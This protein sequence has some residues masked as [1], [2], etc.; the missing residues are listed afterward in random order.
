MFYL[1]IKQMLSRKSQTILIFLGISFGTMIYV[2]IAGL[3]F[4]FRTYLTEQ[5]LNNTAHV[6]IKGV[7]QNIE[8]DPLRKRFYS[9]DIHVKWIS[10]PEG[11]RDEVKLQ[12]PQG[13]FDRLDV[14]PNVVAY[15]PRL[16]I[17]GLVSQGR[18]RT[19]VNITGIIPNR[20]MKVTS[21]EEYMDEGSLKDLNG[22]GNKIILGSGV[23]KDIGAQ[24]GDTVNISAGL[25]ESR[26]FKVVGKVHLG[27]EQI[28]KAMV[29]GNIREIQ[30][31]N[32]S[33]GRVSE[34]SVSLV[35]IKQSQEIA[36]KWAKYTRDKVQGWEEANAQFMQMIQIQDIM[37][38]IMTGAILLVAGFGI[39][40]VLSIMISQKKKE[41]AILRSIGYGPNRI[42]ELFLFQGLM[43][44]FGGGILGIILGFTV[45]KILE[46]YELA[47]EVGKS[48]HLPISY[49]LSI[50]FTALIAAQAAAAIASY[51][52][53]RAASRLTPLEIIREEM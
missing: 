30:S 7:E 32:R 50:F 46:S 16:S 20:Q 1:A 19:N 38:A 44:G 41:I 4:G 25:G 8:K 39:Y 17:N 51:L 27:N 35:D 42:L 15:A 10:P 48:N 21:L 36:A 24:V 22:G 34:I 28:D 11:K 37:R 3:Q 14:D 12:N 52:P 45:N 29:L 2:I 33:P 6:I 26:P 18:F 49:D 31:L 40:N 43:L 23:L 13:W 47:F 53:A 5:L 9:D